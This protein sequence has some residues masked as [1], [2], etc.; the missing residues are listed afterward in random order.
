MSVEKVSDK[1][2]ARAKEGI[3]SGAEKLEQAVDVAAQTSKNTAR[4]VRA[5]VEDFVQEYDGLY[6]EGKDVVEEA[7]ICTKNM[8]RA[9]P[10]TSLAMVGLL[11]Y[12]LGRL[13]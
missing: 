1:V 5:S 11:G 10:L 6:A 13:R 8:V 12:L 7:L 3:A 9:R 4:R 2:A